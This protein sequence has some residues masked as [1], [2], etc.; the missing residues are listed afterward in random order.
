M[1]TGIIHSCYS[2]HNFELRYR[3]DCDIV[4]ISQHD[5]FKITSTALDPVSYYCHVEVE[6]QSALCMFYHLTLHR[7]KLIKAYIISLRKIE[8]FI[9]TD[10]IK[11]QCIT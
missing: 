1:Y 8:T 4:S 10:S 5:K 2:V 7:N 6:Q 11:A 3:R 9:F